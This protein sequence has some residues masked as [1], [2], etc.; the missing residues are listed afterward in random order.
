MLKTP[1]DLDPRLLAVASEAEL[2]ALHAVE[3]HGSQRAAAAALGLSH[4][5]IGKAVRRVRKRALE[6]A[7]AKP[8]PGMF[9]HS[10]T[11]DGDGV[12]TAIR[13]RIEE[14]GPEPC[15]P[16][17]HTIRGVSQ[18]VD[19]SGRELLRWNKTKQ[20]EVDRWHAFVAAAREHAAEYAGLADP[21]P[22]PSMVHEDLLVVYGIGD[23]HC[24]L[25]AWGDEAGRNFDLKI[26]QAQ[27]Q[28]AIDLLV[29]QTPPAAR[30]VV[31]NVGDWFHVQS[32]DFRTPAGG[33]RLDADTRLGKITR[34]GFDTM[35]WIIDRALQRHASVSVRNVRGNHDPDLGVVF[36]QWLQSAYERE[37][38]VQVP[39]NSAYRHYERFGRC[40]LGFT[41]GDGG[42][43]ADLPGLMATEAAQDWALTEN[44][45]RAW[46]TGHIH[47]KRQL[48]RQDYPGV[49]VESFRTMAPSDAWHASKGYRSEQGIEALVFH[50]THGLKG[51][52]YVSLHE[53]VGG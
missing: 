41:H 40:L 47:H 29:A 46:L 39:D 27:L 17:N 6:T 19:G 3:Q 11:T 44:G 1:N 32:A 53:V 15:P 20:D 33:N 16:P 23:A 35:R 25:V 28:R 50:R 51:R 8:L 42:P 45:V 43:I 10:V 24:G 48:K 36:N 34:A 31:L 22:A 9:V 5:V 13:H 18:L 12:P 7:G 38:R 2:A 49:W 26:W 52:T 30:A 4:D 14:A 21:V 37:E